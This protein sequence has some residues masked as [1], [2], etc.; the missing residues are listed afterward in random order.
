MIMRQGVDNRT[1]RTVCVTQWRFAHRLACQR[2]MA[3]PADTAA[4]INGSAH[5]GGKC[6]GSAKISPMNVATA[7]IVACRV[8][9][10]VVRSICARRATVTAAPTIPQTEARSACSKLNAAKMLPRAITRKQ[11]SHAPA[12]FSAAGRARPPARRSSYARTLNL[13]LG[14]DCPI[15]F[16]AAFTT[17]FFDVRYAAGKRNEFPHRTGS[18]LGD[19]GITRLGLA[20]SQGGDLEPSGHRPHR[21]RPRQPAGAGRSGRRR[22]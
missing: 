19:R 8:M 15:F 11:A 2:A 10:S 9:L 21:A 17:A 4:V 5:C 14:I 1:R 6:D 22:S 16:D 13:E 7:L 3:M 20:A 12:N 18:I